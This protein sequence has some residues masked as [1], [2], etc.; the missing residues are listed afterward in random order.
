MKAV[1]LSILFAVCSAS[2]MIAQP[3]RIGAGLAFANVLDFNSGET[4]NPG[5]FIKTWIAIG[6]D[7][8]LH[9]V[10]SV[11]AFNRYKFDPGSYILKNYL[12]HGDLDGQYVVFK[13]GSIKI[14]GFAGLNFTYLYSR[15]D[16]YGNPIV[17]IENA[18]D[19]AIGGNAG[20][21]LEM[22]MTDHVD[23]NVTGKYKF[24][25]YN[26]FVIS[27]SAAY[28]FGGRRGRYFRR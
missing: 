22:R 10:P 24:S 23:F 16:P 15:F 27:V 21:G 26:Q 20:A 1:F 6:R 7:K 12:F 2:V 19:Y 11:T 5:L 25:K 18:S 14:I 28:Y 4:N 8:K 9:V 3:D 13:E 17:T